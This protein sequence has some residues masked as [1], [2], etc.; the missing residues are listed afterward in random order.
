MSL[1]NRKWFFP[2]SVI[3]LVG[4][5]FIIWSSIFQDFMGFPM[6]QHGFCPRMIPNYILW[7]SMILMVVVIVPISYYFISK[8][9]GEKMEKNLSV[10][11]KLVDR[12][13]KTNT[14]GERIRLNDNGSILKLLN[15]NEKKVVEKFIENKG[16]ILQSEISKMESMTKL[17]THRAVKELEKKGIVK[18]ESSGKTNRII[19]AEDIK[20]ILFK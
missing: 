18:V 20:E 10:I 9:L 15:F 11:T 3:A 4:V 8:R 2:I 16:S 1:K 17:K 19:L 6:T 7:L 12:R 5:I 14:K 13:I